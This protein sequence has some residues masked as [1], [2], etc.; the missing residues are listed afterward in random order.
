MNDQ[1]L[2]F[3]SNPDVSI[4]KLNRPAVYNAIRFRELAAFERAVASLESNPPRA[5]I[6]TAEAPGFCSGVDLKES[7]EATSDFARKRATLMH[8][9]LRR[10]RSLP[11]PTVAAIDGVAAGLGCELA[12]SADIRIA[13][14]AS[15]FSYPE[16]KVA[17]PSPAFHL[18]SLIGMSRTQDMLLTARWIDAGEALDWGLIHRIG[19][20]PLQDA[21]EM[22]EEL[23]DLSPISLRMTK[24]VMEMARS[25]GEAASTRLHIDEVANAADTADRR[26]ALE[27]FA[28]RR[29]PHFKGI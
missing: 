9:T 22:V 4:I 26:E 3:D 28:E 14:P 8:E 13:S 27:A 1:T 6:L 29:K 5:L 20:N 10:F 21:L 15:R 16:P 24:E 12:I 7:R 2:I 25:D 11:F 17:V 19:A 18:M 23:N